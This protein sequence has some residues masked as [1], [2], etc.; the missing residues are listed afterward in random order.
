MAQDVLGLL[1]RLE[2]SRVY[3]VGWTDGGV[4]GLDLAMTQPERLAGL[5][6]FGANADVSGLKKGAEKTGVD[7]SSRPLGENSWLILRAM[8][9]ESTCECGD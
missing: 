6:T 9:G 2:I 3:L 4:I 1:D 7:R 8:C 5:F